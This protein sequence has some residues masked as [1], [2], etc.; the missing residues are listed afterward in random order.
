[1]L[2]VVK[3]VAA[4]SLPVLCFVGLNRLINVSTDIAM[5]EESEHPGY[6]EQ[7]FN[8]KKNSQGEIP[9][10]LRQNWYD[11]DKSRRNVQL[12]SN[13]NPIDTVIELGPLSVGGRTRALWI[14]PRNEKILL[15][16]A[17][18]GGIWRSENGGTNWKPIN[19]HEISMMPSCITHNPFNPN[20][21]YYGTGESRANSADVD[22]IGVFY[23]NDG[24]KSFSQLSSTIKKTGF[25]EIW[26]IK[27]SRTDSNTV[28]VGTHAQGLF[29]TTDHGLSWKP[30][31]IGGNKQ[32][33]NILCFPNGRVMMSMQSNQVYGSDK[34]GDSGTF[35]TVKF[36]NMPG[37]GSYRRIQMGYCE[38]FPNVVYAIFEGYDFNATPIR[39]YKSSDFGKSWTERVAP[40]DIGSSYQAYC[41]MLGVSP[42]DSN[43]VVC[44]GVNIAV[45]ANGGSSWVEI[46]TG[47][48]DHHSYAFFPKTTNEYIVGTDGGVF[49]YRW[50]DNTYIANLNNGY[51]VTQFYAGS[52]APSGLIAIS[53]AQDNGTHVATKPYVSRSFFGGDGAYCH[54][55]L[56][57]ASV[58]YM[59]YQNA[60]PHRMDNF[61]PNAPSWPTSIADSRFA[62]DGIDFI[63]LYSLAPGDQSMLFY[64]TNRGLYRSTDAGN[65]WDKITTV[66]R[67]G[68]KAIGIS[69][70]INPVVYFGGT[71]AQLYKIEKAGTTA[72]GKEVNFNNYVPS[73][74][75]NDNIKG[76]TLHPNNPYILY[77]A[78]SNIN[79]QPRV[80]KV[81]GLDSVTNKPV[82][83]NISG[84]LPPGLPVNMMEVDPKNP[85]RIFFAGTDFGLY[86]S[87]DSGK[88]WIKEYRIPN[89]AIH[90]LK[91]RADGQLFAFTHGRGMFTLKIKETPSNK[92]TKPQANRATIEVYPQPANDFLE[93]KGLSN[94][95][96]SANMNVNHQGFTYTI[97]DVQGRTIQSN[98]IP[99]NQRIPT[100][101]IS[102][103]MYLLQIKNRENQSVFTKRI[104]I[105]ST[106]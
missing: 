41:L 56:E 54:I 80:W 20:E 73:A 87:T 76:L 32:V 89:V 3:I 39:F 47:H 97:L 10:W 55:G 17:I 26:D 81:T 7:W 86:Y 94:N 69:N 23:S 33:N 30:V 8:E 12:R 22:G 48:S 103:G 6:F 37:N 74:I 102:A 36:P 59:S 104:L 4:L 91:M 99:P 84:D 82:F 96:S 83:T 75:T 71:S 79:T 70:Q 46:T 52:Y 101:T 14:D 21:I 11:W 58:A 78:L 85:D 1:M 61:N 45:S 2:K 34:N 95:V 24:G 106:R 72:S 67:A 64:R 51:R 100:S 90:E 28:F 63:N 92:I 38:K 44:G 93:I 60:T 68:I 25:S 31:F 18:S 27:H 9:A 35:S 62:N 98:A 43:R 15:A 57:D 13:D 5:G 88:T 65:S 66:I 42:T 50:S 49:K 53:G 29:R 105:S 40:T 77:V 19:E 16:G